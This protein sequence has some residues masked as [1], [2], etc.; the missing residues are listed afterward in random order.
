MTTLKQI[1]RARLPITITA[2]VLLPLGSMGRK[3]RYSFVHYRNSTVSLPRAQTIRVDGIAK[4]PD[5]EHQAT[6]TR[7]A[8]PN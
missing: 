2:R 8:P 3:D 5:R 6:P 7:P 4:S 1:V